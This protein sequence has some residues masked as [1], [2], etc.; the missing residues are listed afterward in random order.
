MGNEGTVPASSAPASYQKH[1]LSKYSNSEGQKMAEKM[2]GANFKLG[3]GPNKLSGVSSY[4]AS[5]KNTQKRD[6]EKKEKPFVDARVTNIKNF[7]AEPVLASEASSK[8]TPYG[9]TDQLA[10]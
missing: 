5:S 7:G 6:Y 8:F 4:E 2:R 1:D 10:Q 3:Q 9:G